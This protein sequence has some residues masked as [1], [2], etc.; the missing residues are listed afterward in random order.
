MSRRSRTSLAVLS[1]LGLTMLVLGTLRAAPEVEAGWVQT[2]PGDAFCFL[3]PAALAVQP[4]QPIDS[5]A[6]RYQGNG[7]RLSFD[8]GRY[9]MSADHLVNPHEEAITV[10]GRP[11]RLLIS[12]RET[13]L[14]VSPVY[15]GATMTT[16][17]TMLLRADVGLSRPIW[18][19]MFDSIRFKPL[20]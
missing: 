2:C 13:V 15:P 19:R 10:D 20:R 9:P 6:G 5:L 3:R 7:M 11:A 12:E 1:S 17:F 16:H 8:M 4:G 14:I 18:Q